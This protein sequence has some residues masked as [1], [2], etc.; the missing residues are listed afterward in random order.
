MSEKSTKWS[1]SQIISVPRQGLGPSGVLHET[2]NRL[3]QSRH[4]VF[5]IPGTAACAGLAAFALALL[6][7]ILG[8]AGVAGWSPMVAL[9]ISVFSFVP[10]CMALLLYLHGVSRWE[11]NRAEG[12]GR[13]C[14]RGAPFRQPRFQRTESPSGRSMPARGGSRGG[15][16]VPPPPFGP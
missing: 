9:Q 7:L 15:A 5:W 16:R 3:W 1:V 2:A 4:W 13:I 10:T 12:L 11:L 6:H 8:L 14:F